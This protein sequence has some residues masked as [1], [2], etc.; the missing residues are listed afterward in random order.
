MTA[1]SKPIVRPNV[2]SRPKGK[3]RFKKIPKTEE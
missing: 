2:A 1:I 3:K